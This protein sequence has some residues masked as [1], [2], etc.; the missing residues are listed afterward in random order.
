MIGLTIAALLLSID[1]FLVS[2]ALGACRI[3]R[4]HTDR[5]ALAFGLCDG[6]GSLVG[7]VLGVSL[8]GRLAYFGQWGVSG[9]D[10]R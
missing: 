4:R 8:S 2:F 5:L 1:S 10:G 3:E 6:A 7:L 9:S